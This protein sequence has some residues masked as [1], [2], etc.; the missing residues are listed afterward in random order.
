[1][2]PRH[3]AI[4]VKSALMSIAV[5]LVGLGLGSTGAAQ[6]SPGR[7]EAVQIPL[8]PLPFDVK[9]ILRRPN[10]A[11]PFPAVILVPACDRFVAIDD[12]NWGEALASWGYVVLTL[13]VFTPHGIAGRETCIYPAPPEIADDLYRGVNLLVERKL[14]DAERIV[15]MG[16]G[17]GGSLAF[18]AVDP[19]GAM[20]RARHKFNAAIAFYPPCGD[21]KGV[22]AVTTL[23]IVGARDEQTSEACRKM[24]EGEDDMGI[25]RQHGAGVPIQ[26]VIL[27][28]AYSGFD[29][30][31]F[32]K[33]VDV[34]GLHVEYS[35]Q[36][37]DK[38]KEI[39][40]QFLQSLAG[41]RQ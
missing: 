30:P 26:L 2:W 13:D 31:A 7:V 16:F 1:M 20:Q 6:Q 4:P 24:A 23:L 19:K 32:Q 21:I 29:K 36:A 34:R 17:R 35:K 15:V 38:S 10:G 3:R 12:K 9:G 8:N 25:S 28:D 14:V 33:P 27:P 22:M 37:A 18:A 5:L 39:V 11:G 40:R 41:P